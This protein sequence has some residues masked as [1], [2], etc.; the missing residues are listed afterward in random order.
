MA[1]IQSEWSQAENQQSRL[2]RPRRSVLAVVA[3]IIAVGFG[4]LSKLS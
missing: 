3:G 2:S 1:T 4:T